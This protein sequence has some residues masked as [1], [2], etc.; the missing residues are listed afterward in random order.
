MA[1]ADRAYEFVKERILDGRFAG[2]RLLTEGD[3]GADV[4]LSR[5]PVRE[6][7]LRLESEHLLELYPKRG[8]IVVGVSAEEVEHVMETRL[9]VERFAVARII[10]ADLEL[11]EDPEACIAR[12]ERYGRDGDWHGFVEEDRRFHRIFVAAAGNPFILRLHDSLRDRQTRMNLAALARDEDRQRQVLAEH[13][14]IAEAVAARELDAALETVKRHLGTTRELL[15]EGAPD[16]VGPES[17]RGRR[18]DARPN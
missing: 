3:V 14:A 17:G 15:R 9:L 13:R 16:P 6:A 5:T 18:P 1:A 11:D 8:A 4:G 10:E 2:G 7:F 12:Q